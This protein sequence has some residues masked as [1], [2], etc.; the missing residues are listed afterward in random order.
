MITIELKVDGIEVKAGDKTIL[1]NRE[2]CHKA[3]DLFLEDE[4]PVCD[5]T[6]YQNQMINGC[7]T[8]E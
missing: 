8:C 2:D 5:L 4:T 3:V 7:P 1:T 6:P